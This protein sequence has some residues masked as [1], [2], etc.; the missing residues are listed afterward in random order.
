MKDFHWIRVLKCS[1]FYRLKSKFS[2]AEDGE[3]Y[4]EVI[5]VGARQI[6][7]THSASLQ[8][9][10]QTSVSATQ[11]STSLTKS[12]RTIRR[13]RLSDFHFEPLHKRRK[14]SKNF[15]E[16]SCNYYYYYH[17]YLLYAGYLY[18]YN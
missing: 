12:L 5:D 6:P 16:I 14:I 4:V 10:P 1:S 13:R 3:E 11:I 2:A 15:F 8:S 17:H 7:P 9:V 18:I